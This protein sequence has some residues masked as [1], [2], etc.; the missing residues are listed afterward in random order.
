[1]KNEDGKKIF[2]AMDG[3][4]D[5]LVGEAA[6]F[7]GEKS[8]LTKKRKEGRRAPFAGWR[9]Y[10]T[11][12]VAVLLLAAMSVSLITLIPGTKK[13]DRPEGILFSG[14]AYTADGVVDLPEELRTVSVTADG[15]DSKI[16]PT[17]SSF[18]ITTCG[19]CDVGTLAKY[20]TV[21]PS[22]YMSVEQLSETEFR[23]RP[24]TDGLV[25]GTVYRV[26]V[27]DPESPAASYAFQTESKLLVKS[28][29]P[30]DRT[31]APV[32][33]GI[34]IAFSDS[35]K[36]DGIDRFITVSPAVKG[37]WYRYP[38]GRT[39]ALVPDDKLDYDTVYTVTVS[40]GVEALSGKK[41]ETGTTSVFRTVTEP[42][43]PG[44]LTLSIRDTTHTLSNMTAVFSPDEEAYVKLECIGPDI[45]RIDSA[46]VRLW[47]YDSPADAAKAIEKAQTVKEGVLVYPTG[48]LTLVRKVSGDIDSS[49]I[50]A[51]FGA[52]LEKGVYLVTVEATASDDKKTVDAEFSGFIQ[53]SSLRAFTASSDGR[54]LVYITDRTGAGA[55]GADISGKAFVPA[56]N[57]AEKPASDFADVYAVTANDGVAVL[58]NLHR[59]AMLLTASSEGDRL[60][61]CASAA[62]TVN[63]GYFMRYIYT[64]REVYFSNDTVSFWG[65]VAP[66]YG[67]DLPGELYMLTGSSSVKYPV[68]YDSDGS[69][70]GSYEIKNLKGGVYLKIVDADG[71]IYASKYIS[72]TTEEKPTITASVSFNKLF[73]VYGD[74]AKVTVKAAFF[75]GTPAAG[76]EFEC[77][78]KAGSSSVAPINSRAV[79]D[80]NGEAVF[81]FRLGYCG[82][83]STSPVTVEFLAELSGMETQRLTVRGS[84]FYFHSSYVYG[85]RY[86]EDCRRFTLNLRDTGAIKTADDLNYRFFEENTVGVPATAEITYRLVKYVIT[87]TEKTGY[88]SYTK[89]TYKTYSYDTSYYTEKT[90]TLDF[91]DGVATLPLYEVKDFSGGYY[92]EVMFRDGVHNYINNV[93]AV[94]GG[95]YIRQDGRSDDGIVT[96]KEAYSVGDT[97]KATAVING[98][99][100]K[101]TLYAVFANGLF[102]YA[103]GETFE[104]GYEPE[105]IPGATVYASAF[106]GEGFSVY[107]ANIAYDCRKDAALTTVITADKESYKPGETAVLTFR[108]DAKGGN[109]LVSIVDEACFALGEQKADAL[110]FFGSLSGYGYYAGAIKPV[111]VDGRFYATR[112]YSSYY[113]YDAPYDLVKYARDRESAL[114]ET[115][116]DPGAPGGDEAG[117][118]KTGY[119]VRK[120]FADNPVFTVV[121]LD[122]NG[123]GKLIFTV[124]DN[125]TTWR[126]TA[127]A[128]SGLGGKL[129]DIKLGTSTETAVCTQPFFISADVCSRYIVGDDVSAA[130]RSFGRL[131]DGT[132]SYRAVLSL[133]GREI[134]E[135]T[136][137]GEPSV[138]TWINFGKLEAGAYTLTV[139]AECGGGRDAVEKKFS[140]TLSNISADVCRDVTADEIADISPLLYPLTLTFSAS[141]PES[142]LYDGILN[143]LARGNESGRADMLAAKYIALTIRSKLFGADAAEQA[144]ETL[145]ALSANGNVYYK[146]LPYSADD[147]LL[148]A[149]ILAADA[150]VADAGRRDRLISIY[151]G[152]SAKD[153]QESP[154]S[155]CSALMALAAMGEPVLDKLYSVASVAKNYPDEA[156]LFLAAAFACI[157]DYSAA[158]DIYRQVKEKTGVS[159][160]EYGTLYISGASLDA[161]VRL[162]SAAMFSAAR[163]A[164]ADAL[165]MA[166]YL[167][168]NITRDES[169]ELALACFVKYRDP[170]DFSD[171]GEKTLVYSV[172]G[173]EK[174]V[175]LRRG[176]SYRVTLDRQGHE[177]FRLVSCDGIA[178]K[179]SYVGAASEA[180]TDESERITVGKT[181]EP[182]GNNRYAVTLTVSGK[183][184][185]V[186]ESFRITDC[187]PSGAR[188]VSINGRTATYRNGSGIYSY[189]CIYSASGQDV[190]GWITI[191]NNN[192]ASG[193]SYDNT[194]PEYGFTVS[195]SYIIRGAADGEFVVEGAVLKNSATGFYSASPRSTITIKDGKM[196]AK[197]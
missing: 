16:I 86:D 157:G 34:E 168:G 189:A 81:A 18:T 33:T 6:A 164:P 171:D 80:A 15:S 39:V 10:A 159:D 84:A 128:A 32:D 59:S 190:N 114:A 170:S 8:A 66:A 25:P 23:L 51:N 103:V 143:R 187:V 194:C 1:M 146:L 38:D 178:I 55:G 195:V 140:V 139:Y 186:Y 163:I 97:V 155:L 126:V 127:T 40:A 54:T 161:N 4:G 180:F 68:K 62:A 116:G 142:R 193:G 105:L 50:T 181:V 133:D 151:L 89:R 174:T 53:I 175:E 7:K 136:A 49:R 56:D 5:D 46:T 24:A 132:V 83:Y 12:A 28:I 129:E 98:E 63:D 22:T 2:K 48:G 27:G 191:R 113:R 144:E 3:I 192:Y 88:D 74:S 156:K 108:T 131:A 75:D 31:T 123:E 95:Y 44:I 36:T 13:K 104:F 158:N 43:S 130:L 58:E 160:G 173:E 115:N 102:G 92:Y 111:A 117:S 9:K 52:G 110:D 197:K 90:G 141:T 165:A 153:L 78:I 45:E 145:R 41:L 137:S 101:N 118:G 120:N 76:Y 17:D 47:K 121:G 42:Q 94:K 77:S 91:R 150:G 196:T 134:A 30:S 188:Y 135:R 20:L 85:I 138:H 169:A 26:S 177:T 185:K 37:E 162:T 99:T 82:A 79:T 184:A 35:V 29:L 64:D 166:K 106:T 57:W 93:G 11:A 167:S 183:S 19:A 96:D 109:V 65:V 147:A 172:G 67:E 60:I 149:K 154:E 70:S 148:T 179:A 21:S 100:N 71:R 69:F 152:I 125:L 176:G 61:V 14:D 87:K 112:I 124:P 122:E 119:Y 72:I 107:R 182:C 73:Y